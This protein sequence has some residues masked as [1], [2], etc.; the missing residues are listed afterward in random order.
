MLSDTQFDAEIRTKLTEL[1]LSDPNYWSYSERSTRTY[2]LDYFQ[3]PAMMVPDML[4][5]LIRIICGTDPN[6]RTVFDAFAG[7]GSVLTETMLLGLDFVGGDIN[8][9]AVLLCKAKAG[10]FRPHQLEDKL[11]DILS[12]VESDDSNRREATFP[13]LTKWFQPRTIHELSK[14]RRAIRAEPSLWARRFFWI[15]LAETVRRTSN[16]RTSTF[17]LHV[18]TEKDIESRDLSPIRIFEEIASA[19][20]NLLDEQTAVLGDQGLLNRGH[21]T[22]T[23]E[24]HLRSAR[25]TT[26]TKRQFDL[27]VTSP[28]YGDNATTV[29]YG[30]HSYLPLQWIDLSDI[31]GGVDPLC[32][33]TTHEI[34]RRSLGGS[35]KNALKVSEAILDESPTFKA[36]LEAL[37]HDPIDRRTRAAA[38]IHDLDGC[39]EP[40]L[41]QL[42]KDAYMIWVIGNRRIAGQQLRTDKILSELLRARGARHVCS[43]ARKIPSKRMAL[44][45]NVSATMNK[46]LILVFRN[47][48]GTGVSNATH[49]A[50]NR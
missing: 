12:F 23:T 8:P 47:A 32:L 44:K 16:S 15:V 31:G 37:K 35:R 48:V 25:C 43:V 36:C 41:H 20:I 22:G 50:A 3:Y 14:L 45:N 9:L 6:V 49:H 30:Q 13:G 46:E 10:P 42:R 2:A 39:I 34:D 24:I 7:S 17:K 29:P 40:L 38:F 18:R 33:S 19:N 28:P 21:Y 11:E 5:D 4:S 26:T 27:L 1:S